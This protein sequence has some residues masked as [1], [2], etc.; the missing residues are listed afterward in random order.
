MSGGRNN[1]IDILRLA[2][3]FSIVCLHL[4]SGSGVWGA[5]EL[6]AVSRF[7]VP[8][9]FLFSGYFA[10]GAAWRGKLRQTGKVLALTAA[11]NLLYLILSLPQ[12]V[13]CLLIRMRASLLFGPS[14]WPEILLYNTSPVSEHLWFLGALFNCLLLDLLFAGLFAR[15][16]H[17]RTVTAG[18]ALALLIGG[19]LLYHFGVLNPEIDFQLYQYRNFLFLGLPFFLAGK[20]VRQTELPRR[21]VPVPVYL[22]LVLLLSAASVGEYRLFGVWE[23]YISSAVLALVLLHMALAYPLPYCK[24]LGSLLAWLGKNTSLVIYILHIYVLDRVRELYYAQAPWKQELSVYH[25]LPLAVFLI[26]MLVGVVLALGKAGA[27]KLAGT[28]KQRRKEHAQ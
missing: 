28:V 3:A 16:K 8:L 13:T 4:F 5:E 15:L 6:V 14:E 9:F 20:L 12:P 10:A 2:A 19:L 24:G 11:S 7:A 27:E 17:R 22:A 18:L 23:L 26:P 21:R 1:T 25:L